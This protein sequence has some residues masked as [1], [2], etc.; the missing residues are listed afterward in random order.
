MMRENDRPDADLNR[1]KVN[2]KFPLYEYLS[3]NRLIQLLKVY[4][5]LSNNLV[6][7]DELSPESQLETMIYRSL[8]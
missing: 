3:L 4:E 8:Y 1:K 5:R 2:C 7:I 6:N